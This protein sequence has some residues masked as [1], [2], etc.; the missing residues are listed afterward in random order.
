M[1]A[2]VIYLPP[3]GIRLPRELRRA[4]NRAAFRQPHRRAMLERRATHLWLEYG[5]DRALDWLRWG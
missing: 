5:Q 2:A 4:V 3:V 1:S